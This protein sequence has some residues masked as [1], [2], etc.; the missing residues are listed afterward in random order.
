MTWFIPGLTTSTFTV[1]AG[2]V[3]HFTTARGHLLPD[4]TFPPCY[5][6]IGSVKSDI[7]VMRS[8]GV[9]STIGRIMADDFTALNFE[10]KDG[11]RSHREFR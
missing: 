5:S 9:M 1:A 8:S 3:G 4:E 7:S 11:D 2:I 6:G 10:V